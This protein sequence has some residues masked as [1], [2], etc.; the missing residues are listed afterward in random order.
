MH[1]R[2]SPKGGKLSATKPGKV[3]YRLKTEEEV[4]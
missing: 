1:V 2:V 3:I 4:L